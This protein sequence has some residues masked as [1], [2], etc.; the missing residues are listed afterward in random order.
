MKTLMN[1]SVEMR[2]VI[3]AQSEMMPDMMQ[4]LTDMMKDPIKVY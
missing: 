3:E 1:E 2:K 4:A